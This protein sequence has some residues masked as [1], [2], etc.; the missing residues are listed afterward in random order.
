MSVIDSDRPTAKPGRQGRTPEPRKRRGGVSGRSYIPY[1]LIIP[2][3]AVM[4]GVLAYPLFQ[5]FNLAFQNVNDYLHLVNPGTAKY[6]GFD[7]F[8]KV[9]SSGDFWDSVRRTVLL[10][11]EVVLLSVVLGLGVAVLLNRVSNWAKVTVITVLMFVWAIP[12]IV[13]GTVFR[14]L[15]ASTSGVVDYICYL[16]GGKGMLNHDW[17]AD[18]TQGLYVVVAVS[19]LWGA[20]PFL[21]IG[22][23]AAM[24]QVPKELVEAATLDGANGW[25]AFRH[26][27]IPVIKPFLIVA[28]ALS[29]I[30]DFQV[31]GQIWALRQN[32]P[33]PG[34]RTIGVYLY[35][36]GIGSSHYSSSA[37]TSIAMIL[38]MLAVLVFY[39]RQVVK[40]GEQD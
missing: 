31:F 19:V 12:A 16:F 10:V 14:W 22:F 36:Q 20:L 37:V 1:A 35:M 5:L 40:I 8:T 4:L 32:S 27:V 2:A 34:Y 29:V 9:L 30:W 3:A 7:G 25:Q 13:T 21:V 33:E 11:L 26:V 28:T 23:N 6:I 24:T 18:P 17:F 38:L 15:F 39:I